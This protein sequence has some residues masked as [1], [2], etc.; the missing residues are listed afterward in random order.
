MQR[1]AL[2]RLVGKFRRRQLA[3]L[4]VLCG[5][6]PQL[7]RTVAR[8][9]G[10]LVGAVF[11]DDGGERLALLHECGVGFLILVNFGIGQAFLQFF[12]ARFCFFELFD[13]V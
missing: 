7:G 10:G 3:Q 12:K 5:V 8:G 13:H 2:F 6:V 11:F 9:D 1:L 4:A